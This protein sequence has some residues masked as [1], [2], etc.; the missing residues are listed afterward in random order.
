MNSKE[1]CGKTGA[2]K[3]DE[4]LSFEWLANKEKT[5]VFEV[6]SK[7]G[8]IVLGVVRW[9]P[10]WRHYCYFPNIEE[11]TVYSDRCLISIGEFLT[12]LNQ[13]HKEGY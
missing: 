3:E 7:S 2:W 8:D 5:K 1:V 4:W 11:E 13:M 12:E 10:S 9:H 6:W